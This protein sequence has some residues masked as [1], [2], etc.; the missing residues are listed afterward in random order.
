MNLEEGD[1]FLF[2]PHSPNSGLDSSSQAQD[3]AP[4]LPAGGAVDV[5]PPGLLR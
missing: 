4:V 3:V 1:M 5:K 2:R